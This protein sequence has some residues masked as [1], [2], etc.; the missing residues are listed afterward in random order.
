MTTNFP[1]RWFA[2]SAATKKNRPLTTGFESEKEARAQ[3]EFLANTYGGVAKVTE[4]TNGD[5]ALIGSF[6]AKRGWF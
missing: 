5:C 1:T 4:V 3:A 6:S 2:N